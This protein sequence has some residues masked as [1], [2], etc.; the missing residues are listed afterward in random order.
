LTAPAPIAKV[1]AAQPTEQI[2]TVTQSVGVPEPTVL[3]TISVPPGLVSQPTAGI[4]PVVTTAGVTAPGAGVTL[5]SA[6]QQLLS[7]QQAS[8]LGQLTALQQEQQ[9]LLDQTGAQAGLA[10]EVRTAMKS[11]LLAAQMAEAVK[12]SDS[13][14][15][16]VY[17][18]AAA[19]LSDQDKDSRKSVTNMLAASVGN[20]ETFRA[21]LEVAVRLYPDDE[22]IAAIAA[23]PTLLDPV[24][25]QGRN[26]TVEANVAGSQAW[27][28]SVVTDPSDEG[29]MAGHFQGWVDSRWAGDAKGLALEAANYVPSDRDVQ[30][31][32]ESFG[33]TLDP[34]DP[35]D[36]Q[37]LYAWKN[38]MSQVVQQFAVEMASDMVEELKSMGVTD[39]DADTME[40]IRDM[41]TAL[42]D[43]S[44]GNT[45]QVGDISGDWDSDLEN[46]KFSIYFTDWS[47][48]DIADYSTYKA[49]ALSQSLNQLW[50]EMVRQGKPTGTRAEFRDKVMAEF[51]T[52]VALLR[53][54]TDAE[55]VDRAGVL[56]GTVSSAGVSELAAKSRELRSSLNPQGD[57]KWMRW[58]Q[59]LEPAQVSALLS[60]KTD[61]GGSNGLYAGGG[62]S[63]VSW[64]AGA[65]PTVATFADLEAGPVLEST[66][67]RAGGGSYFVAIKVGDE[68][69]GVKPTGTKSPTGLPLYRVYKPDGT[70]TGLTL[71]V[72]FRAVRYYK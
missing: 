8:N 27:L 59:G 68:F 47:G 49:D 53:G 32:A 69:Y 22:Y 70:D 45:L 39:M 41:S 2:Q 31:Y 4:T 37:R 71:P 50:E 13:I 19:R 42:V 3:E 64:E 35:E 48:S 17:T 61:N 20:P 30:G 1:V 21:W 44:A 34:A 65:V 29:E 56:G 25:I 26:A 55:A 33:A 15:S 5:T 60:S 62:S 14:T 9:R 11:N 46:G 63:G 28:D 67:D 52:D 7:H 43:Q 12:L 51:G 72:Q 24:W 40:R 54:L 36:R 16:G 6:E 38:Y 10:G 18:S 66:T 57:Y 23:D 58:L